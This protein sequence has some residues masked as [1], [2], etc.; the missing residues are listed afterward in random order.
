MEIAAGGGRGAGGVLVVVARVAGVELEPQCDWGV[1]HEQA[2]GREQ[3]RERGAGGAGGGADSTELTAL[4]GLAWRLPAGLR[5]RDC[6]VAWLGEGEAPR[7]RKR[8]AAPKATL[9]HTLSSAILAAPRLLL[10]LMP[11]L[12]PACLLLPSFPPAAP[13]Q[14][15]R[16]PRARRR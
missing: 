15:A 9:P 1:E 6:A 4:G 16:A 12:T 5:L 2:G 11:D 10:L 14:A 7:D 3:G 13:S 8:A